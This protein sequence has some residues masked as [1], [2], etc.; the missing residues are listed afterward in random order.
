MTKICHEHCPGGG[1]GAGAAVL[2][3]IVAAVV[4]GAARA[5]ARPIETV[6][7][8]A[9]I[10][11]A[12]ATGLVLTGDVACLVTRAHR[13]QAAARQLAAVRAAQAIEAPRR[14]AIEAP[15]R[16]LAQEAAAWATI[17]ED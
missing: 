13:R 9:L 8:I 6:A 4:I 10:A 15:Q 17:E 5:V 2:V 11:S 3:V 14:L 1:S 7:K 12:A 16:R